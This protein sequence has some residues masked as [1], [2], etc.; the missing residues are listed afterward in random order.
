MSTTGGADLLVA[1]RGALLDALK[2]LHAHLDAVIVIGAQ[3]IYLHTGAARVALAE[4]TKE[5]RQ[6]QLA[7][8]VSEQALAFL[9]ELFAA[10]A[11]APGSVMAGRAEQGVGDPPMVSASV[12]LLAEDLLTTID[13]TPK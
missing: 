6:D 2:A 4:A 9:A 3:A 7:G 10:G 12:A 8:V 11:D 1:A 5:L 13:Q